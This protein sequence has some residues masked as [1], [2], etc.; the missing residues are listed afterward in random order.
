MIDFNK[1]I[2]TSY[3]TQ[4]CN[5]AFYKINSR[6]SIGDLSYLFQKY[7]PT[8]Y[9]DFYNKYTTDTKCK[10]R[11]HCGRSEEELLV[12][13]ERYK[14]F[15]KSDLPVEI[16][17]NN[18]IWHIIVQTFEGHRKEIELKQYLINKGFNVKNVKSD[19]D[20]E[21]AIDLLISKGDQKAFIQVKPISFFM[22]NSN[23]SL[24]ND[25]LLAI[26]KYKKA[27]DKFGL[28]TIYCVYKKEGNKVEWLTNE[29]GGLGHKLNS[30]LADTGITKLSKNA[31]TYKAI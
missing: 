26:K 4:K 8:D 25:R 14:A 28:H 13:A 1:C 7:Q 29:K 30:L 22:G 3:L 27:L 31:N 23:Q 12:I 15:A 2:E 9:Q 5:M 18:L 21:Y 19:L 24:L 6:Q 11:R 16:F 10:D 20:A 17:F